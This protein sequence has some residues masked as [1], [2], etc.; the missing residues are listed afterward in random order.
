MRTI[1]GVECHGK[2]IV[3][4]NRYACLHAWIPFWHAFDDTQGFCIELW[5]NTPC[6]S[7]AT[8]TS[9]TLHNKAY[10]DT[11][12]NATVFAYRG[13]FQILIQILKQSVMTARKLR[14]P[15]DDIVNLSSVKRDLRIDD[16]F[17]SG[18]IS[19]VIFLL[20]LSHDGRCFP[21][22]SFSNACA[23]LDTGH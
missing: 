22:L 5:M 15:L 20:C 4:R 10:N 14:H 9:I 16:H 21:K 18:Q 7:G 17:V 8:D 2:R 19:F 23:R 12:E 1:F 6:H 13:I 3:H 11:P